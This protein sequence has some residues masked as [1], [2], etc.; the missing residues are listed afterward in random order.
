VI[1]HAGSIQDGKHP[2]QNSLTLLFNF[3]DELPGHILHDDIQ[4]ELCFTHASH[5]L[6]TCIAIRDFLNYMKVFSNFVAFF[7]ITLGHSCMQSSYIELVVPNWSFGLTLATLIHK[8]EL[9]ISF[10]P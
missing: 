4:I 6:H 9:N 7:E 1:A 2:L 3:L 10:F 5:M 8:M